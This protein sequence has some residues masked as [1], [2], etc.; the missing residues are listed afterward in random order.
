M[1]V[2]HA[3]LACVHQV[4][5]VL[6]VRSPCTLKTRQP[7]MEWLVEAKRVA[8]RCHAATLPGLAHDVLP[9]DGPGG[10]RCCC[11]AIAP[12][13]VYS[14]SRAGHKCAAV[15]LPVLSTAVVTPARS[16]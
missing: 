6:L 8:E 1:R 2:S 13:V 10:V 12:R 4:N 9:R 3:Q 16:L 5:F 15:C 14:H 11:H 7:Q